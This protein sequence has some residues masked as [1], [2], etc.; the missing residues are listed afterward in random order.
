MSTVGFSSPLDI[1]GMTLRNRFVMS[2]LTRNR[3]TVD[4]VPTDRDA[5]VSML[6]YYEQRASAGES[7]WIFA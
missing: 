3:A 4:L 5:E 7:E 2:P 1:K 6:E